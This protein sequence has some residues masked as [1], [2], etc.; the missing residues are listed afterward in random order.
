MLL[1]SAAAAFIAAL[2]DFALKLLH[3]IRILSLLG[4]RVPNT[5]LS[6]LDGFSTMIICMYYGKLE[7]IGISQIIGTFIC[8][9]IS[10]INWDLD[11]W[12]F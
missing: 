3:I 7:C 5:L 8:R 12:S 11:Y 2:F 1:E 4:Q 6:I 9:K 10:S